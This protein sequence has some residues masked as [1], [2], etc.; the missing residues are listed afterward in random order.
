MRVKIVH[1]FIE[2]LENVELQSS[3]LGGKQ[4]TFG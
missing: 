4:N 1:L 3:W 2:E